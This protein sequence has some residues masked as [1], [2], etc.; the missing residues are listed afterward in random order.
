MKCASFIH[1]IL[2]LVGTVLAGWDNCPEVD[3]T[4]IVNSYINILLQMPTLAAA[5]ASAQALLVDDYSETSDSIL[6]LEGLPVSR[7]S[8][9]FRKTSAFPPRNLDSEAHH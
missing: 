6:T 3:S 4:A 2:A 7:T 8:P 5:N 9:Q 1:S